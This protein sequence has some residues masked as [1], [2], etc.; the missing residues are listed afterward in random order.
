MNDDDFLRIIRSRHF[1][2]RRNLIHGQLTPFLR[3]RGLNL[4][5]ERDSSDSTQSDRRSSDEWI[6]VSSL[7]SHD[8]P[9]GGELEGS[10]P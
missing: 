7:P 6:E 5:I 2:H 4:R 10:G 8:I 1:Q 3:E 9:L